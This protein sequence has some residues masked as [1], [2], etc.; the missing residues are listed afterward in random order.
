MFPL[1]RGAR[2]GYSE[3]EPWRFFAG[4][5]DSHDGSSR[6][7]SWEDQTQFLSVEEGKWVTANLHR[8]QRKPRM[9]LR[10]EGEFQLR[11]HVMTPSGK[12]MSQ[13]PPRVTRY[14]LERV[15]E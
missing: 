6:D 15:V 10:V 1:A 5:T 4:P 8:A 3:V 9:P 12:S 13:P 7:P 2:L 14:S 11:N